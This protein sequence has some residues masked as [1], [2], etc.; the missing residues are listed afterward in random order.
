MTET[1]SYNILTILEEILEKKHACLNVKLCQY[2]APMPYLTPV[3]T[4]TFLRFYAWP[5][6]HICL[7][8]ASV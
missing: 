2:V 6:H 3:S 5:V 7:H 1:R 8:M 4:S